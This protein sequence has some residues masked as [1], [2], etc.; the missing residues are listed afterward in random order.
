MEIK[1]GL[2]LPIDGAPSRTIDLGPSVRRVA[3]V[4]DD[5]VGLKPSL[6]V[7]EGEAVKLGQVLLHDKRTPGISFT[8]PGSGVV[9]AINRGAKR[10]FQSLEIELDGEDEASFASIGDRNPETLSASEVRQNLLQSGLWTAL[11]TRPYSQVPPL[12]SAPRSIFVTAIDTYPLAVPPELVIAE[13][14]AHFERGVKLL[15]R[16]TEGSVFVCANKAVELSEL[17]A[18]RLRIE[19]FSGPH[20]AGLAGTHIHFLDPVG[21]NKSVW[22]VNY[23][24]V[25]AM[26]HLFA[27][28]RLLMD[29]VISLAGPAVKHPR[30][31]RTRIG[32][33]TDE[34][35]F[36]EVKDGNVRI[37]SGSVLTGRTAKGP[38]AYLGRFHLQVGA[39]MEGTQRVLLEWLRP[40]FDRFSI[41]RVF[42]STVSGKSNGQFTTSREGSPRAMVPVG[43]YEQV[44]PLD[45]LPTFLLRSLIVSDRQQAKALGCL[46]LDEEDLALCTFVCPGKYEYGPMLRDCLDRIQRDG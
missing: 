28:G 41:K 29:R 16:L 13:Q 31:L 26:G 35:V 11:R 14:F 1:K 34:L 38:T 21:E 10:R 23:Q 12:E 19:R 32:A 45:V 37:I 5:Y 2:D 30:L 27:T 18:P 39:L 43:A 7:G 25:I 3:I 17:S 15:S 33:S 40:G 20:P 9:A 44:M 6:A 22:W 24:D 42:A 36:G 8:S 46:E 4:G